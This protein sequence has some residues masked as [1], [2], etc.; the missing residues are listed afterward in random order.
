MNCS[1]CSLSSA[2]LGTCGLC[3]IAHF[4]ISRSIDEP[5]AADTLEHL[6]GALLIV[7]A[8][9]N[10]R[11]VTEVELR[12][13]AVQVALIAVLV[14]AAHAALEHREIRL[15]GIGMDIIPMPSSPAQ[16]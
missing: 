5:L 13:I 12:E 7:Y 11:I 15:D 4:P 16:S 10:T 3:V 14:S 9:R 1:D 6:G 8:Q 2:V